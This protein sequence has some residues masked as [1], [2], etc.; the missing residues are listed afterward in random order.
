MLSPNKKS[1]MK[2]LLYRDEYKWRSI[3]VIKKLPKIKWSSIVDDRPNTNSPRI[4][5]S[6]KFSEEYLGSSKS[7]LDLG[8]GTG[9]YTYIIDR[10]GC[11]GI[12]LHLK[13]LKVAKKY[14]KNS[15]FIVS[16]ALNLPFREGIF[17]VI[18]MWE[19][20]EYIESGSEN[21]LI[22]EIYRI[23]TPKAQLFV[24]A[25]NHNFLYNILDP[26]YIL[27]RQ[28]H[29]RLPELIDS[30]SKRGFAIKRYD[31]RGSWNTIIAMNI[32]YFFKHIL[33]KKNGKILSHFEE[34]SE[35]E[36][37]SNGKK[38][39]TNIFIAAEKI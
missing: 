33:H 39:T 4:K 15:E 19:V 34:K 2:E 7:I 26:D 12:D 3:Q 38:G 27:H 18:F 14:C 1:K 30:I 21:R 6:Q 24:S 32:F 9:S 10:V 11:V 25:P 29:F 23:S 31:I 22:P 5:F 17:E 8:C 36:L 16:S 28:R 20:L 35:N 13:A 37:I